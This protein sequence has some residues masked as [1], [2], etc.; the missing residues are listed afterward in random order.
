MNPSNCPELRPIER[1]W[2]IVKRN[3]RKNSS[4]AT[5]VTSL[6]MTIVIE[7][8]WWLINGTTLNKK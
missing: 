5:Y 2:A 1:F 7:D 4:P 8:F 6:F 3:L